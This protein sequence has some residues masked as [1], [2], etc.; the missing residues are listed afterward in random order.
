MQV[1]IT[2]TLKPDQVDDQL[3]LV[4]E[5]LEEY[6]QLRPDGVREAV[7][8]RDD[9]VSVIHLVDTGDAGPEVFAGFPAFQRARAVLDERCATPPELTPLHEIDSYG[10]R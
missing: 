7:Y 2:Y 10:F 1:L 4:R 5:Y 6:R 3:R 9:K 8:Q